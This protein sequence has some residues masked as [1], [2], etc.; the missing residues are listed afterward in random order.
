MSMKLIRGWLF[1][2][3]LVQAKQC[4][5]HVFAIQVARS[6]DGVGPIRAWLTPLA[7]H[8]P[9]VFDK[10]GIEAC[11]WRLDNNHRR[12]ICVM[13]GAVRPKHRHSKSK[14]DKLLLR[15]RN[16]AVAR[17]RDTALRRNSR[18]HLNCKGRIFYLLNRFAKSQ[19]SRFEYEATFLSQKAASILGEVICQLLSNR[20]YFSNEKAKPPIVLNNV[21]SEFPAYFG[22]F[23]FRHF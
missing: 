18:R 15:F 16:V 7:K 9:S 11:L 4:S 23:L 21:A 13:G 22:H 3:P 6:H 12:R 5:Y 14:I 1:S 17:A 10:D 20:L 2:I 19:P 8:P